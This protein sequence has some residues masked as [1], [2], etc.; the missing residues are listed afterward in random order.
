MPG[1]S[2]SYPIRR[3]LTRSGLLVS[4]AGHG[5]VAKALLRR[6]HGAGAPGPGSCP[7]WQP[8]RLPFGWRKWMVRQDLTE[9][10][11]STAIHCVVGNATLT[12]K[13]GT[14]RQPLASTR[15]RRSGAGT[16]RGTVGDHAMQHHRAEPGA[17]RAK[18]NPET[19]GVGA[20]CHGLW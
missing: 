18:V 9:E 5:V 4:N 8:V 3:C 10:R 14:R 2:S 1:L 11:L 7:A 16:D 13:R 6:A 19:L 17:A 20:T 15:R 12:G